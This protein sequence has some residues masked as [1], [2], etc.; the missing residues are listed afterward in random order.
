MKGHGTSII[1]GPGSHPSRIVNTYLRPTAPIAAD[2]LLPCNPADAMA[3]AQ[4]LIEGPLMANHSHGLWGYTGP[5][6]TGSELT[7]QS[8][9]IGG[10]SAAAVLLELAGHGVRRAI[11]VGHAQPLR[12][13][14]GQTTIIVAAA[15]SGD[16]ASRALGDSDHVTPDAELTG[17]LRVALG[18]GA[19]EATVLSRDLH[20][21]PP[22]T[23]QGEHRRAAE[24]L[25]GDLETAALL[26]AGRRARVA[27][28]GALITANGDGEASRERLLELGAG[29][30]AALSLA[31]SAA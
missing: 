4:H 22:Q 31:R 2:V 7:I 5:T 21:P 17:S 19:R 10:P 23:R 1:R 25:V 27:V 6:A 14:A 20:D 26:A 12:A 29:C 24:A 16:G 15:L 30:A 3:L 8:T 9:G 13:L 28:A 18:D 11:R